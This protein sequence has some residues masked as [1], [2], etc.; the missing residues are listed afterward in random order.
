MSMV[1]QW[2]TSVSND[3]LG[4]HSFWKQKKYLVNRKNK[5][6][7]EK[8]LSIR[9]KNY[10]WLM[11]VMKKLLIRNKKG[12][13]RSKIDGA[14]RAVGK[15]MLQKWNKT[16]SLS[17]N[18]VRMSTITW[19]DSSP[20]NNACDEILGS[21]SDKFRKVLHPSWYSRALF[22]LTP[23]ICHWLHTLFLF[24]HLNF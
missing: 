19:V 20:F 8:C 17:K 12:E 18:S 16:K 24:C 3:K 9:N 15:L 2:L 13:L 21:Y 6:R 4:S 7:K 14:R 5:L 1:V 22:S 10:N 23:Y 11:T